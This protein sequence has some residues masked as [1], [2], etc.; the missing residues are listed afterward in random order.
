[1]IILRTYVCAFMK[2][3]SRSK[4]S[5][6][7]SIIFFTL[8]IIGCQS[9]EG[10]EP[11]KK[12][13][14]SEVSVPSEINVVAQGDIHIISYEPERLNAG[15]EPTDSFITDPT[16]HLFKVVATSATT[17]RDIKV[18]DVNGNAYTETMQRPKT[19]TNQ[20]N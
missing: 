18:T 19:F 20:L 2:R 3:Q 7:L 8:F 14:L 1:M 15:A 6:L 10:A 4:A 5:G 17:T 11:D 16:A 13:Q 9:N 12:I